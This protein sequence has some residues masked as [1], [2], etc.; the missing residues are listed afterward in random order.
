MNDEVETRE[1]T[2]SEDLVKVVLAAASAL[3]VKRFVEN[4]VEEGFRRYRNP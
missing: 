1:L 4:A 3:L 2:I